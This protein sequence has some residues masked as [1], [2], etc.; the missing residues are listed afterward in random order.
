MNS[1]CQSTQSEDLKILK[2]CLWTLTNS[3]QVKPTTSLLKT[4]ELAIIG[5]LTAK[6]MQD[7]ALYCL[8]KRKKPEYG[9]PLPSTAEFIEISEQI[10]AEK[11]RERKIN[12][13]IEEANRHLL[14]NPV[15]KEK[16]VELA[17]QIGSKIGESNLEMPSIDLYEFMDR[18]GTTSYQS[19]GSI[20][21]ELF[22][23]EVFKK[24]GRYPRKIQ[25]VNKRFEV[26]KKKYDN[27]QLR[28]YSTYV[29]KSQP[30]TDTELFTIGYL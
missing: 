19:K 17:S 3:Y 22:R 29:E 1:E 8:R 21:S 15:G 23:A 16:V 2:Q 9:N 12:E 26:V 4:W 27:N 25:H 24:C 10:E 5:V 30:G 18:H 20:D 13:E 11:A 7:A 6:Q 28:T 14:S